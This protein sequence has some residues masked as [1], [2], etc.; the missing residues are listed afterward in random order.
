MNAGIIAI[1]AALT[2]TSLDASCSPERRFSTE[3]LPAIALRP[4]DA[5]EGTR[6]WSKTSGPITFEDFENDDQ[7]R[8]DLRA[9]GWE[10]GYAT[11]FV[12][13]G[14]DLEDQERAPSDALFVSALL[15]VYEDAEAAH[16][17]I[18]DHFS[19]LQEQDD[20]VEFLPSPRL[21]DEA[22]AARGTWPKDE[23]GQPWIKY[24]WRVANL[25][26]LLSIQGEIAPDE[27]LDLAA[28]METRAAREL[29]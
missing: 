16:R 12:E 14:F 1:A 21:G 11:L 19:N 18:E 29:N 10:G 5:L 13:R 22:R 26:T 9:M 28:T 27:A 3:D 7:A 17:D 23:G 20:P 15:A 4:F 6:Y 8:D 25:S 2:L 24:S